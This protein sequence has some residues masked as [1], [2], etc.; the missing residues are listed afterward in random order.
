MGIAVCPISYVP[1]RKDPLHQSELV[2]Q[3]IFGEQARILQE[4]LEWF[5]IQTMF[6]NYKGWIEKKEVKFIREPINN[7]TTIT[8]FSKLER[9]TGEIILL[10]PGSEI[11]QE[12]FDLK[13]DKIINI[14]HESDKKTIIDLARQFIGTPY[15][16]GGRTL[17]GIDCS[18]FIQIIHKCNGISFPRDASQQFN[19]GTPI[20]NLKNSKLCDLAFFEGDKGKITHVGLIIEEN[21]ILHASGKVRID[22]LDDNGIYNEES[23]K[24]THKLNSIKRIVE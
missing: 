4:T 23:G 1:I 13:K 3:L 24:Y 12:V 5:F 6:D 20:S 21:K 15:L 18:G 9:H 14:E 11:N 17:M 7:E 2:S 16:W 8:L 10:S 19:L 22:K